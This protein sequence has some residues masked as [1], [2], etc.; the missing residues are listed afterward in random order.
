MDNQPQ[1]IVITQSAPPSNGLGTT[2][3]ILGIISLVFA[4][5]PLIGFIAWITSPLALIFGLIGV[6]KAPRGGAI[7]GIVLGGIAFAICLLW[8][9]I[10]GAAMAAGS[11]AS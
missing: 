10:F 11:G 5:I 8:A 4:F 3:M 6:T 9:T 2:A 7:A 1:H